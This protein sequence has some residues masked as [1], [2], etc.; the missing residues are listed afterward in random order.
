MRIYW[1]NMSV[2]NNPCKWCQDRHAGCHTKDC[3]HGWYEWDKKHKEERDRIWKEKN[4]EWRSIVSES[5]WRS[6]DRLK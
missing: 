4:D 6:K 5:T 2:H 1:K 3:P